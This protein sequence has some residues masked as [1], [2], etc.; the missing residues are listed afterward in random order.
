MSLEAEEAR[1]IQQA[2]SAQGFA[3]HPWIYRFRVSAFPPV[4]LAEIGMTS[5]PFPTA[6]GDWSWPMFLERH[7]RCVADVCYPGHAA[8]SGRGLLHSAESTDQ[9]EW[10]LVEDFP[11]GKFVTIV[12]AVL[13]P[14]PVTS[15]SPAPD[16]CIRFWS[17]C[18]ARFSRHGARFA[19]GT[20][21]RRLFRNQ[22]DSLARFAAGLL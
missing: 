5:F 15:H 22:R 21:L 19:A 17:T 9:V 20:W 11:A 8:L 3:V 13:H 16:I 4:P 10:L 14:A 12:Y 1:A 7:C 2:L 18:G 6:V